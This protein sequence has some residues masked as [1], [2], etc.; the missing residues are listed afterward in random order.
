MSVRAKIEKQIIYEPDPA[1]SP[2]ADDFFRAVL[3]DHV[4]QC[5]FEDCENET[6]CGAETRD[7]AHSA[8]CTAHM[9]VVFA[10]WMVGV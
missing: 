8:Y 3:L 1:I 2:D 6:R 4:E 5:C 9:H 7:T 10:D